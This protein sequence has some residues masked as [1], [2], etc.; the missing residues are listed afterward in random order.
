MLP[1]YDIIVSNPP[2][3]PEE[4]KV[5]MHINVAN[6]E[7]VLALFTPE[8]DPLLFYRAIADLGRKHLKPGGKIYCE[9]H[10]DHALLTANLF[11]E[12]RYNT[13]VKNDMHGNARMLRAI[14]QP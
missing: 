10:K 6:F 5:N 9:L 13:L 12:K 1:Q 14:L 3:I 7:P 11:I 8:D 4:E 2:Y